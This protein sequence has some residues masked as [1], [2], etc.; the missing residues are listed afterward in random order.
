MKFKDNKI[1]KS[2]LGVLFLLLHDFLQLR[3]RK[4]RLGQ[5]HF[6]QPELFPYIPIHQFVLF[7]NFR[8][9]SFQS[10]ARVNVGRPAVVSFP[11]CGLADGNALPPEFQRVAFSSIIRVDDAEDPYHD[12]AA[13]RFG[14]IY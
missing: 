6:H 4:H 7:Y 2:R 5:V 9:K 3:V 14:D 12:L 8:T 11:A 1:S 10:F 13:F